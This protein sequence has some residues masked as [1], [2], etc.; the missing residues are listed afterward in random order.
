MS[1]IAVNILV[2]LFNY[3]DGFRILNLMLLYEGSFIIKRKMPIKSAFF[4]LS[5][6]FLHVFIP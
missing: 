2:L 1:E 3:C 5:T 4:M 6:K